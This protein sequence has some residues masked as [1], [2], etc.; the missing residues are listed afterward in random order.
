MKTVKAQ[1]SFC[2]YSFTEKVR[3][4]S[5]DYLKCCNYVASFD[6]SRY[7]FTKK[8]YSRLISNSQ[9]LEDFLDFHGAKNNK[10]WFFYREMTAAVRHLSLGCYSQKHIS[11][12]LASYGLEDIE[13]FKSQ[14]Y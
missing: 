4:F 12:R 2:D 14:G 1:K 11:N 8:L 3:H 6:V 13:D 7:V 9:L 10:N 5:Y